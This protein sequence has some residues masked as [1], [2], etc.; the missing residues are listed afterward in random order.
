[1]SLGPS[2][3]VSKAKTGAQRAREYRER[4]KYAALG[5]IVRPPGRISCA[6]SAAER[7][8]EYRQRKKLLNST[9]SQEET[10]VSTF[11]H[12]EDGNI[13]YFEES[14]EICQSDT[15]LDNYCHSQVPDAASP[16]VPNDII[17]I[18]E[19]VAESI[20]ECE[21][22]SNLLSGQ[23][24]TEDDGSLDKTVLSFEI[25]DAPTCVKNEPAFVPAEEV[26]SHWSNSYVTSMKLGSNSDVT[27]GS[28]NR[29]NWKY[30]N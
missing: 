10:S 22:D 2:K 7:M 1:M 16:M 29:V 26:T 14:G 4:K 6:K 21:K 27:A 13:I 12:K 24:G 3:R 5:L 11:E 19:P 28:L 17:D 25:V 30:Y 8:R 9:N 15:D 23:E 20:V 18:R